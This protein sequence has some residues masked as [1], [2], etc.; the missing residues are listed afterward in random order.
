MKPLYFYELFWLLLIES[1]R[2]IVASAA[3]EM[4]YDYLITNYSRLAIPVRNPTDMLYVHF[5][6]F[7]EQIVEVDEKNQVL[8][9][10]V[11]VKQI[12]HD[13][14]LEWNP[15]D[16]HGI[17]AIRLPTRKLWTPDILIYN[18][19]NGSYNIQAETWANVNYTGNVTW[20]PPA[21]YKSACKIDVQYFPFDEQRCDIKFGSWTYDGTILDLVPLNSSAELKDYWTNG[22]WRILD[23]PCKR[24]VIRYPCCDEPYVDVT[25]TSLLRRVALYYFIYLILPNVLMSFMTVLVFYLPPCDITN[26]EKMQLTTCILVSMVWFLLLVTYQIPPNANSFPLIMKYLI[27]TMMV[28]SSSLCLTVIT[29]NVR[30][31]NPATHDM[32]QWVRTIFIDTVPK[33]V[34]MRRPEMNCKHLNNNSTTGVQSAVPN[35]YDKQHYLEEEKMN[36][37]NSHICN[38]AQEDGSDVD[39][40]SDS[41][42]LLGVLGDPEEN[43]KHCYLRSPKP[44]QTRLAEMN[45]LREAQTVQDATDDFIYL[46]SVFVNA[47]NAKRVNDDWKYVSIVLDRILLIIYI[48][49]VIAGTTAIFFEAPLAIEFFRQIFSSGVDLDGQENVILPS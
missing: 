14:S 20:F 8:T 21:V 44:P 15:K 19:A 26:C 25:C 17:E 24:N 11:W 10:K 22:E 6:L 28:I 9:S 42:S 31:R 40:E 5:G 23:S 1:I 33:Y 18:N 13:H 2:V 43:L 47:D 41:D 4:L 37:Y 12:W 35:K 46:K 34:W 45:E 39:T 36:N 16:F 49:A 48:C 7:M 3:E 29:L 27:F 30:H 32:P 38:N